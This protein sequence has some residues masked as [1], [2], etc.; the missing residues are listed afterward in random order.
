VRWLT[1]NWNVA[2]AIL[3]LIVVYILFI[4]TKLGDR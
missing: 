1:K 3:G 4:L 2:L